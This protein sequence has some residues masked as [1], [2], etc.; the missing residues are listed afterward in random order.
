MTRKLEDLF[1]LPPTQEEVEKA[2]PSIEENR[3]TIA[4]IDATI[5]KIDTALPAVRG[6][7]ATDEEMDQLAEM[8]KNSYNDLMDLG[9][10]VDSRF[11]SEI[12]SVASNMLGHA[13]TAKTAKLDKKLKMIDLQLKKARL[14][15]QKPEEPAGGATQTGNGVVIN[16]TELLDRILNGNKQNDGKE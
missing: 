1:N 8:A 6:L 3:N 11:A 14:D 15:Q 7:E 10:Q 5:D 12:F 2:I 9:M 13:I 16:R 4:V